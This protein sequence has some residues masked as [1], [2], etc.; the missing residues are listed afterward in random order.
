MGLMIVTL[1]FNDTVA[2]KISP[3]SLP[4]V[5]CTREARGIFWHWDHL[6]L[7]LLLLGLHLGSGGGDYAVV[8]QFRLLLLI[9]IVIFLAVFLRMGIYSK[10]V[11]F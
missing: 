5:E 10:F 3:W 2:F 8:L 1:G 4:R 6:D 7:G 9:G 11:N